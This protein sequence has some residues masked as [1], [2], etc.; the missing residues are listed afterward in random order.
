MKNRINVVF[1][2]IQSDIL[3][4]YTIVTFSIYR[5]EIEFTK[6]SVFQQGEK[7]KEAKLRRT[8]ESVN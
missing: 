8:D 3:V 1:R 4:I 2:K 7:Q 6:W 5:N